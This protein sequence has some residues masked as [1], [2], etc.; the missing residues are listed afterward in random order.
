M[1]KYN[2]RL[3]SVRI[4]EQGDPIFQG[5]IGNEVTLRK[6]HTYQVWKMPKDFIKLGESDT[7]QIE[8]IRHKDKPIY[9]FQ[10]HPEVSGI[11]GLL[12]MRNFLNMCGFNVI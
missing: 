2:Q 12:I 6:Q 7:C 8:I 3:E 10:S 5:L 4:T 1:D 11:N 9:G